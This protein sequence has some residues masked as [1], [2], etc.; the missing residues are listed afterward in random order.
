[1]AGSWIEQQVEEVDALQAIFD[2]DAEFELLTPKCLETL[3]DLLEKSGDASERFDVSGEEALSF[4]LSVLCKTAEGAEV[5]VRVTFRLPQGYPPALPAL[6]VTSSALSRRLTVALREELLE[7]AKKL[8]GPMVMDLV[9]HLREF[10]SS[11]NSTAVVAGD[12][13]G[14][15]KKEVES[16]RRCLLR[17]DHMHARQRYCKTILSWCNEL[18]L[19]GRLLFQG[20]FILILL[21]G[22]ASD[23]QEYL[24]RHRTRP[25][26]VDSAGRTCK[27]RMLSVLY[28]SPADGTR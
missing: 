9:M 14:I 17:V 11:V 27:E 24:T 5:M 26:D 21:E 12:T 25:V 3:R 13:D 6:S 4:S 18:G 16:W 7:A 28:D 2:G 8:Q 15:V 23:V 20:R 10:V 19:K 1:M 22:R